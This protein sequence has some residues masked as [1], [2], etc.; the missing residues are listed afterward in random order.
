[1]WHRDTFR[2]TLI[3]MKLKESKKAK[4]IR[5]E[6][7][8]LVLFLIFRGKVLGLSPLYRTLS[9]GLLYITFIILRSVPAIVST[10]LIMRAHWTLSNAF[11][12]SV[13]TCAVLPWVYLYDALHLLI[14]Y[15]EPNLP[16]QQEVYL[17][18]VYNLQSVPDSACKCFARIFTSML[19]KEIGL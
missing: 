1:M 5:G 2:Q 12:A 10:A 7:G 8:I 15:V 9:M 4:E 14:A 19:I 11:S 18:I 13:E 3:H 6:A 17:F 16:L